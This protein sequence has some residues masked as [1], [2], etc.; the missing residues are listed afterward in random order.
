MQVTAIG[1]Y[2]SNCVERKSIV[3]NPIKK[4]TETKKTEGFAPI[5]MNLWGANQATAKTENNSFLSLFVPS[6][7]RNTNNPK[8][9]DK[10]EADTQSDFRLSQL[11]MPVACPDCGAPVMTKPVFTEI[12]KEIANANE[13]TYLSV[14]NN[15]TEYMYPQEIKILGLI[16]KKKAANPDKTITDIVKDERK[17]RLSKLE[18]K[19]FKTLDKISK[20]A[21]ENLDNKTKQKV[22]GFI[23]ESSDVIFAR[24][25]NCAFQ[26]KTF[27]EKFAELDV[28]DEKA[29]EAMLKIG[30]GL[31][32]SLSSEDAWFVKYGAPAKDNRKRTSQEICE[33]LVAP[34]YTNTDHIHPWNLG[35]YDSVSNF[36]LMHA[37]CNIIKSDKP[38]VEWLNEDKENRTR[39]IKEYLITTQEAIDNSKDAKMHPKY[40]NYAA[41]VAHTI[42]HETNGEIDFT[43]EFPLPKG[44]HH[45]DHYKNQSSQSN[46]NKKA[47]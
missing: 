30:A 2:A 47:A 20:Y 27:L 6:F 46:T 15:H 32:S 44:E 19:Q 38:F 23:E 10:K 45:H 34:T 35:G 3:T 13:D 42:Y 39:Y 1:C 26:R 29:K 41:K 24:R 31:P 37:R 25:T 5:T 36:W 18:A 33:K 14:L 40:D 11:A 12:K 21:D 17:K 8:G 4:E 16:E 7:G 43:K 22:Q 28:K 9:F